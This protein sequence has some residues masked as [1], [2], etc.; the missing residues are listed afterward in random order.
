MTDTNLLPCPFCGSKAH[1]VQ[2]RDTLK[3]NATW[4]ECE[5]CHAMIETLYDDDPA[6]ARHQAAAVWNRRVNANQ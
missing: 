2:W 1:I 5:G 4:I 3:P 6:T